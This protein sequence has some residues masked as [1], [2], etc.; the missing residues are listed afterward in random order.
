M[1]R[2][3]VTA[4]RMEKKVQGRRTFGKSVPADM[5]AEKAVRPAIAAVTAAIL[6]YAAV[7]LANAGERRLGLVITNK[8]YS[9]STEIPPLENAHKDGHAIEEA[10]RK[11]GFDIPDSRRL[12]D[13]S[14]EEME[15]AIEQFSE[16]LRRAKK[17]NSAD[18]VV[19][20]FYYSGH[21]AS[22]ER[23]SYL[24]PVGAPIRGSED[25]SSNALFIQ[26]IVSRLEA[27]RA[28]LFGVLDACRNVLPQTRFKG[29]KPV[30]REELGG[31]GVFLAYAAQPGMIAQ[32]N[33]LYA[34]AL[35]ERISKASAHRA[36]AEHANVFWDAHS[37]VRSR[38][39]TEQNPIIVSSSFESVLFTLGTERPATDPKEPPR[40]FDAG[41][42]MKWVILQTRE[43]AKLYFPREAPL[44]KEPTPTAA[45]MGLLPAGTTLFDRRVDL[46]E[47]ANEQWVKFK[48]RQGDEVYTRYEN[49]IAY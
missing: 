36:S 8:N 16:E 4:R 2:R 34:S 35:A 41:S 29:L 46:G 9:S 43:N 17:E 7:G 27:G 12:Y 30:Q 11:V 21:G 6:L 15:T 47:V 13:A 33:H 19:G 26:L 23:G 44:F 48:S 24:I 25:L 38:S 37:E 20:F 42:S 39:N 40:F 22:D 10:L 3:A 5:R 28:V 32:D 18:R 14:K 1:V 49:A 31:A 45:H